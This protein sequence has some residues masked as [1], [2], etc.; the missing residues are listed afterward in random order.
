MGTPLPV[1]VPVRRAGKHQ[2]VN[3]YTALSI[4]LWGS[5]MYSKWLT[6]CWLDYRRKH[7]VPSSG[8]QWSVI[9]PSDFC[10]QSKSKHFVSC[11]DWTMQTLRNERYIHLRP[12]VL[13]AHC[14]YHSAKC[15]TTKHYYTHTGKTHTDII[16][17]K[18]YLSQ[19][20]MMNIFLDK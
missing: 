2:Q 11:T 18:R 13:P 3:T 12:T 5:S 15:Q 14:Q 17:I 4:M 10:W 16:Y 19:A 20:L 9:W 8:H 1:A 6:S 7:K